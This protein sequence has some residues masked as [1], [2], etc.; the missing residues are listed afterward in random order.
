MSRQQED[1]DE[2][3]KTMFIDQRPSETITGDKGWV[4][5]DS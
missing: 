2:E 3:K 1:Q 5:G 4:G